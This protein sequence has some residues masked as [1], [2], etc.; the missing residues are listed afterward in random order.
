M[1]NDMHLCAG[2]KTGLTKVNEDVANLKNSLN[3]LIQQVI[4]YA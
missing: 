4:Q 1:L 2:V 3:G